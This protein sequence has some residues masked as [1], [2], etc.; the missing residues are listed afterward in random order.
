M[1]EKKKIKNYINYINKN[2]KIYNNLLLIKKEYNNIK[3]LKH[4]HFNKYI[5]KHFALI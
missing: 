4:Q 2:L 5:M 3:L 1:V